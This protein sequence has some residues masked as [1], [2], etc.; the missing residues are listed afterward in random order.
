[1]RHKINLSRVTP[2]VQVE[3]TQPSGVYISGVDVV[4][5][6]LVVARTDCGANA[7]VANP[8]PAQRHVVAFNDLDGVYE[9]VYSDGTTSHI[10]PF[11]DGNTYVS[12]VS[13]DHETG[14]LVLRRTDNQELRVTLP[15]A[16]V[17]EE[18]E[19]YTPAPDEVLITPPGQELRYVKCADGS[20]TELPAKRYVYKLSTDAIKPDVR[21]LGFTSDSNK[22][23]SLP[24][25]TELTKL[26]VGGYRLVFENREGSYF[27]GAAFR[28][29]VEDGNWYGMPVV[30][31]SLDGETILP[32][33]TVQ[34]L[35]FGTFH[36]NDPQNSVVEVLND[37][38]I[39][40]KDGAMFVLDFDFPPSVY[41]EDH[42][43]RVVHNATVEGQLFVQLCVNIP[44]NH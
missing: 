44:T 19:P 12:E 27:R 35:E 15:T 41:Q 39:Q 17:A 31:M 22:P 32:D 38:R 42:E 16:P 8:A 37:G 11:M 6:K 21:N 3:I 33:V 13:I 14:E 5:D 20:V 30:G 43:A 36:I 25:V 40:L 10:A 24:C 26:E 7:P 29:F 28:Y 9:I 4:N 23:D 18:C 34:Q 2:C 1:M